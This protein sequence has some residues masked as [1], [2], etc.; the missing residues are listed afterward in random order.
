MSLMSVLN[1]GSRALQTSQLGIDITGQNVANADVAGYSRKRINQ[2]TLYAYDSAFGQM[3]L[4]ATVVNIERM[5]NTFLDTQ[6]RKQ[7]SEVGYFAEVTSSFNRME[8]ILVEPSDLGIM[9]YLDEFFSS[10][11]NLANNPEDLSART[12]VR[13]NA[14]VMIDNF[15]K[16]AIELANLR[17]QKNDEIPMRINRVN[18]LSYEI[19]N[20]NQEVAAVELGN[21]NANDSRDRRDM[22][23]KELSMLIEIN[24]IE[25][26][27]GQVTVTTAGSV[28]IA[29]SYMQSLEMTT[30]I[31]EMPDGTILRD[32]GIRFSESKLNF[33]PTG[34]QLRGLIDSRDIYIPEYQKK[35]DDFAAAIV[36]TINDAHLQGY[37][38]QGYSG[39]NFFDPNHTTAATM[40][41]APAIIS[42]VQN[43]AAATAHQSEIAGK[44]T[45]RV[46]GTII[47]PADPSDPASVD[48]VDPGYK[49]GDQPV[50]LIR[51]PSNPV[52]THARNII[53][54]TVTV[55]VKTRNGVPLQPHERIVLVEG[56][57]YRID[58]TFGTFQMLHDGYDGEEF[59]IDFQYFVGGFK[60]PGDNTNALL[61]AELRN[62]LTMTPDSI[63]NPTATFAEYFSSVIGRLGLNTNQA[64]SNLQTRI[65]LAE[66]YEA[67][68]DMIAGV[69]LDE[70]MANLIRFQHTYTAAARL[71][72][73]VDRMLETLLNM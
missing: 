2:T 47:T 4:G 68:Q 9:Y 73:T 28:L 41:L 18:Q 52:Q 66:Q 7:N 29:P 57:D 31:R 48:V 21:Q 63:G 69:S 24:V 58:Y 3:G 54:D 23:L 19:M 43:I 62:S 46:A 25:N 37:N 11:Q 15:R 6:I 35:L 60:G 70:E 72:T 40:R 71:I 38:L 51:D 53:A 17:Q 39:F 26:D 22:L 59:D 20:L 8:A 16:A 12:M 55:A 42:N 34:G 61:I 44:N 13:T 32:V 33:M 27:L 64:Q 56:V 14:E 67:Q 30:N 5:R 45:I 10:W 49:F 1:V 36:K 65:F 50:Q